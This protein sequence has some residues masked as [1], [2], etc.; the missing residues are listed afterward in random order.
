MSVL[1][2]EIYLAS[3]SAIFFHPLQPVISRESGAT[4]AEQGAAK[5][6]V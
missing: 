6:C 5:N 3:I 4:Q 1:H 2:L